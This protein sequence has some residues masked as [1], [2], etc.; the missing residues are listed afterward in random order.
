MEHRKILN[1]SDQVAALVPKGEVDGEM[2]DTPMAMQARLMGQA[3]RK[4]CH[5]LFLSQTILIFISQVLFCF[6]TFSAINC[7][8][9]HGGGI[10]Y[11]VITYQSS[12]LLHSLIRIY[13]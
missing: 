5:S 8:F 7:D 11:L 12:V 2:G 6:S 10:D 3:L 4:L 1:A 9:L 13:L